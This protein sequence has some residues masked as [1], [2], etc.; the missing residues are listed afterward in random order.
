MATAL[1]C[2]GEA[3]LRVLIGLQV[4]TVCTKIANLWLQLVLGGWRGHPD[5]GGRDRWNFW[6]LQPDTSTERALWGLL[7]L[8]RGIAW[9]GAGARQAAASANLL[10]PAPAAAARAARRDV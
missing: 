7:L 8:M 2:L 6:R 10:Q 5:S 3:L 9:V 4:K 1:P